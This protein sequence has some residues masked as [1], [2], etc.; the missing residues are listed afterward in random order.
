MSL[1]WAAGQI[2][3]SHGLPLGLSLVIV[4]ALGIFLLQIFA[5]RGTRREE[6]VPVG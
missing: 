4:N 3:A 5:S 6:N 2:S 1:P